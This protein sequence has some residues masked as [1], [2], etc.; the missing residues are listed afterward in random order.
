MNHPSLYYVMQTQ[1]PHT[2]K[3]LGFEYVE[4][5]GD[6]A[7][8]KEWIG[9]EVPLKFASGPPALLSVG[10]KTERGTVVLK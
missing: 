10:I 7:A 2:V 9:A 6:E 4:V 8:I 3:P 1:A 5:A